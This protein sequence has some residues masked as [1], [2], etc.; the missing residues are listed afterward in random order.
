MVI[1]SLNLYSQYYFG[2][3]N[4]LLLTADQKNYIPQGLSMVT[5]IL[6]TL[7]TAVIVNYSKT[8]MLFFFQHHLFI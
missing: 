2:I 6:N 7:A 1:L 8:F 4:Q 3:V 5:V